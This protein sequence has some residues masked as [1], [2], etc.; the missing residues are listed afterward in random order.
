MKLFRKG[1]IVMI[2]FMVLAASCA[3]KG[4]T[5]RTEILDNK[6]AAI[7]VPTPEWVIAYVSGGNYEV[8]QLQ[9]YKNQHCFVVNRIDASR[10]FA[11]GWVENADGPAQV[12]QM[13]STTVLT[14]AKEKSSGER[15]GEVSAA[16][17]NAAHSM[18]SAS[19]TGLRKAA[20]WWQITRNKSTQVQ[21]AQAFALYTVESRRLDEQIAIN[22][23]NIVENNKELSAAERAI[24]NDLIADIRANGFNNR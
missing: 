18:A 8:E 19:F 4:P 5:Q 2:V 11:V 22:L 3:T 10:D 15:G 23:A 1:I 21:E 17:E 20:D 7:G 6:G 24:Y 9:N 14:D 12:A 13:I 16:F